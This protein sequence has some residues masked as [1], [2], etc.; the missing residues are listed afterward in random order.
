M[1]SDTTERTT[2][3]PN[4]DEALD[5]RLAETVNP[6]VRIPADRLTFAERLEILLDEYSTRGDE[7]GELE[8]QV[9]AL[10]E[11]L[12]EAEQGGRFVG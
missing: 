7:I 6:L 2:T 4:V 5:A 3:R 8:E 12:E 10:R 9:V 1:P 11:R